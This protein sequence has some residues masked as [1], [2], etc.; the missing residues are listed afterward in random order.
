MLIRL[1][2]FCLRHYY[3]NDEE[4]SQLDGVLSKLIKEYDLDGI[5]DS[6]LCELLDAEYAAIWAKNN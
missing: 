2:R 5:S 1:R 3:F 6:D 4:L